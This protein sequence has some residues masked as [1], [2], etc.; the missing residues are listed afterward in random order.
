MDKKRK[1][2]AMQKIQMFIFWTAHLAK[3]MAHLDKFTN[4]L[5]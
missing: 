4:Y 3:D 5:S 2:M 1:D